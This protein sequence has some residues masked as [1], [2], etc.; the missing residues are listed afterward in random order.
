MNF[1]Q[2]DI[3]FSVLLFPWNMA[4]GGEDMEETQ[5]QF[6]DSSCSNNVVNFFNEFRKKNV[7]ILDVGIVL[8]L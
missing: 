6:S 3:L 8:Y 2:S 5:V 1:Y 7:T 4:C